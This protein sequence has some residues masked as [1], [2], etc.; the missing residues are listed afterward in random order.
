MKNHWKT[1]VLIITAVLTGLLAGYFFFK[2]NPSG[3]TLQNHEHQVT[4]DTNDEQIWTCSMH[5]QI[6][7]NEPGQCP[8]CGM[9]LIPVGS[10]ASTNDPMVMEMTKAAVKLAQIQTVEVTPE[11]R[12]GTKSLSLTGR[13]LPDERLKAS[14]VSHISGRIEKLFISFTGESIEKGQKIASIYSPELINAQKELIEATKWKENQPQLEEAARNKLRYWKIP[15]NT[16]DEI[17]KSGK[18]QSTID[19]YADQTGVVLERKV[20][21]GD[22]VKEGTVLFETAN[23]NQLWVL[24]DAYEDD[25]KNIRVGDRV[26][27]TVSSLPGRAFNTRISFIDPVINPQTRVASLRAEVRNNSGI[28]KPDMFVRGTI[29]ATTNATSGSLTVPKTAVMWTGPRSVV[30]LEIPDANV[31]SYEFREVE[32]GEAVG[33]NYLVTKGLST[34]DRVVVNGAFVIDAAAQLNNRASM[35]NRMVRQSGTTPS[36]PDFRERTPSLFR[37]QLQSTVDSYLK[38]KDAFVDSNGEE[39]NTD[40]AALLSNIDGIDMDLLEGDAHM[41]WM[42]KMNALKEHTKSIT[43]T[44]DVEKQ[45]KQFSYVTNA[46]AEAL[47]AFG[48]EDTIYLQHCPM[49]FDNSGAD[50]LSTEEEIRNP[51]FGEKMMKCGTIKSTFIEQS[52]KSTR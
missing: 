37:D 45:R 40:A 15:E 7:Q 18:I 22:Y 52:S 31:P 32:I 5:P 21:V 41:F 14:Q 33:S 16:I 3:A 8:I 42:E 24:F 51:Y 48:T 39:A 11:G 17:Q 19:L 38:L 4:A 36:I 29:K 34:G 28:L 12:S 30:Y 2:N 27:Y 35:M 1:L 6:R 26:D 23:L 50:W 13:I 9:D 47:S 10:N 25:L 46:L 49:A 44:T 20:A 43:G